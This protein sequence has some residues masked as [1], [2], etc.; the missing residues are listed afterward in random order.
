M[1]FQVV[2][3]L[4]EGIRLF[5]AT[6]QTDIES[7]LCSALKAKISGPACLFQVAGKCG[8]IL[9]SLSEVGSELQINRELI[10]LSMTQLQPKSPNFSQL[11]SWSY[12]SSPS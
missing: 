3:K 4:C 7:S 9:E 8:P 2:Q 1:E 10:L 6:E 5:S 11:T 12:L